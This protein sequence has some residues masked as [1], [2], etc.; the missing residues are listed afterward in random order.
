MV[1]SG[2]YPGQSVKFDDISQ[3]FNG[4]RKKFTTLSTTI[5]GVRQVLGLE[6]R[7][8]E[9]NLDITNNIFI[10]INDVLQVPNTSYKFSG[11]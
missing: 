2:F 7:A 3:F 8:L 10:Y 4:F 5:N 1:F 9:A 11:V 6:F